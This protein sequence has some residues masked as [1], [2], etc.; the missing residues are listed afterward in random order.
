ME[1][2][3]KQKQ[4]LNE[5]LLEK[6]EPIAIVGIGM[7]LPGGNK[8][9]NDFA[10]FLNKGGDGIVDIPSDRWDNDRFY[11]D[12]AAPGSIKTRK[13]GYLDNISE[14]DPKFFNISP[15]E[16][17]YID[18]QHR[19]VLEASWQALEDAYCNVEELRD[20]NGGVFV[21]ISS[22]DYSVEVSA[23]PLEECVAPVGTGT[24]HSAVS[25]RVSYFLGWRGPCV[26]ID[27]A[28]S[29]SLV[30]LH[31]SVQAL[32]RKECNIALC[33]GVN[34]IHHPRNLIVFSNANMLSPDGRCNTFDDAANGYGRSEGCCMVVLKRLSDAIKN[35]DRIIASIR[36]SAV[37]QDG[38]SGGL[39]VPNGLAQEACMRNA[40]ND[41]ALLP[42]DINY[43]EAHG[44]GTSLGDPIELTAINQVFKDSHSKDNPIMVG[45][46]KGN[47]GHTEAAAGIIGVAKAALQLDQKKLYIQT[48]MKTRSTHVDWDNYVVDVPTQTRDWNDEKRRCIVNSFGFAGTLSSVVLEEAP[49]DKQTIT[50]AEDAP[51]SVLTLSAKSSAA[52]LAKVQEL[53]TWLQDQSQVELADVAYSSNLR[54]QF[55]QRISYPLDSDKEE[56]LTWLDRQ[57]KKLQDNKATHV[58]KPQIAFLFTGQGSQYVG[59]GSEEYQTSAIYRHAVD[60][61]DRLFHKQLGKSIKQIMLGEEENSDVLIHETMYTQAA[62]FTYEYA[63]SRYYNSIGLVPDCLL[64]HS[65]GELVALCVA[66]VVDL[67]NAIKMVSARATLMQSVTKRGSMLA[68]TSS[69]ATVRPYVDQVSNIDFAAINSPNQCV[70]SGDTEAVDEIEQLLTN[71][72]IPCKRLTTS[73]A[74]HSVH[75]SEMYEPFKKALADIQFESSKIALISNLHGS[76][77][78]DSELSDP[79]YWVRH[80]GQPVRF[81]DGVKT[82]AA[83]GNFVC[84]EVG[85]V[86]SLCA[87]GRQCAADLKW[88]PSTRK[89]RSFSSN[90]ANVVSQCF[91]MGINFDWNAYYGENNLQKLDLPFYAFDRQHYWLD[92]DAKRRFGE[93]AGDNEQ[94]PFLKNEVVQQFDGNQC[95]IFRSDISASVPVY[96]QS[97]KVFD[98]VVFPGAG[99]VET[100]IAAQLRLFGESG[101][102]IFDVNILEPLYLDDQ[103]VELQTNCTLLDSGDYNVVISS[104]TPS[105]NDDQ[106]IKRDHVSAVIGRPQGRPDCADDLADLLSLQL[107][108]WSIASADDMY[109][110]F[111][112]SGLM[113]GDEFQRLISV[114]S[115]DNDIAVADLSAGYNLNETVTPTL[116]DCAMQSVAA[117]ID[118]DS[119]YLPISFGAVTYLKQ[120]RGKLKCVLKRKAGK[121]D[122]L[123]A[124]F[125]ILDGD[126]P[127]IVVRDLTL[128]KVVTA[129]EA[130]PRKITYSTV[131]RKRTL[132]VE[133]TIVDDSHV[134]IN[135]DE[136]LQQK[137]QKLGTNY[138]LGSSFV[139]NIDDARNVLSQSEQLANRKHIVFAWAQNATLESVYS[140]LLALVNLLENDFPDIDVR[141][142]FITFGAQVI[143]KSDYAASDA[144]ISRAASLW[145]FA[146]SLLNEYPRWNASLID[147]PLQDTN[148]NYARYILEESAANLSS[149]NFIAYR[150]GQRHVK[151][152][153][154]QGMGSEH[155]DNFEV[156][157]TEY[158]L[159]QNV[160]PVKVALEP[161]AAGEVQ[162]EIRSAG[163]NFKDVLNALGL[164]KQ[165]AEEHE[166]EHQTL[167]L[168]FEAS[169]VVVAVGDGCSFKLGDS[170]MLSQLGCFKKRVNLPESLLVKKP[171]CLTHGEAAAIPTAY[172]TAYYSLVTLGRIA[173]GDR[174]LIHSAAG[175]VGQ[176]AVQIAKAVGAE[177]FATSSVSKWDH[178]RAQGVQHLMNS[179]TLDFKKEILSITREQGVDIVLNSLNKDYIPA[180]LD[181]LS[182]KGRFIELGK[183]GVWSKERVK[184]YAPEVEYHNFDLSELPIEDLNT[185][186]YEILKTVTDQIAAGEYS[187][188]PITEYDLGDMSEAF[189]VLSRGANTGKLVV[190]LT[191]ELDNKEP[192]E[193]SANFSYLITGG[194]GAL[195]QAL[196]MK[197]VE[198]GA[199][200]IAL[201][202]R[203]IPDKGVVQSIEDSLPEDVIVYPFSCDIG[204]EHSTAELFDNI[205]AM[206]IPLGG[207]FHTA[208]VLA[209]APVSSQTIESINTVFSAKVIGTD[210]LLFELGRINSSAFF[211]GYSSIASI[212]GSAGQSNY[213]AA[214]AYLD[215]RLQLEDALGKRRCIAINWGA[216][217]EIGMAATMSEQQIQSIEDRGI[218][219]L[220][221]K[222]G[223]R[224]LFRSFGS[225]VSN[226]AISEFDWQRYLN[227]MPVERDYYSLLS[228]DGASTQVSLIDLESLNDQ[229]LSERRSAISLFVR[230]SIA[231]VLHYE[232]VEDISPD[233]RFADLGLDS[234]VAVELKNGMEAALGIRLMTS[235]VFDY[236]T[237]PQLAEFLMDSIWKPEV[238][239]TEESLE[240]DVASLSDEE[241]DKALLELTI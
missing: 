1:H 149:E 87:L 196:L 64:G 66:G 105:G 234:L 51:T 197:L 163:L 126:R 214:N 131:W 169:G 139:S 18:P 240:S 167:P 41:S 82:L 235:L 142:S 81:A 144:P 3:D 228:S 63:M 50:V 193:I 5:L 2:T 208:G 204:N 179:R 206:D 156:Q 49:S 85:P 183:I 230:S 182:S 136:S 24:A 132:I 185:L 202:G 29:S 101:G 30:A 74:F 20:S 7:R 226:L 212:L 14:F 232:D 114:C 46:V 42:E 36:G 97:H 73:H 28:C 151:R 231:R 34:A 120:P 150:Q 153:A 55:S 135:F 40:I 92:I 180:G 189:E 224:R 15:K 26:S 83:R 69:E 118:A 22:I 124:D 119:T 152:V 71:N 78:S 75:M 165:Y 98:R 67:P 160:K 100:L 147:L 58:S 95:H 162:I 125:I 138:Q 172:I 209:D 201:C 168:G 35:G 80:V 137:I 221:P 210:N 130:N 61:C 86:G 19:L 146:H 205:N 65:I 186:N 157:I 192:I 103:T 227:S 174:I 239:V 175:G 133:D 70:V 116:L 191:S 13:G 94:H 128:K 187:P 148:E 215:Y 220:S 31:Q 166:I 218:Y 178:L 115:N 57:E 177:I 155:A 37:N 32:R 54:P 12:S 48:S 6:Y 33:G 53:K 222:E 190:N 96:L 60:A 62:L 213:A 47:I 199:K 219:M 184:E 93:T 217:A 143:D 27:T 102:A 223:L 117:L 21:G 107:D 52:L 106:A 229:N 108:S 112:Q 129:Q 188:L 84:I 123:L 176:A 122:E 8:S 44:T 241:L 134:F 91:D 171:D 11:S 195:G 173:K 121:D 76:V 111:E 68:I 159:F 237:I 127:V 25:G 236:P 113:Y 181:V 79:D 225:G 59:M 194:F 170:V 4:L 56:L 16:A 104:Y 90:I 110:D 145:G 23:M 203:R 39:T 99:F 88:L 154:E 233:A 77:A 45:S 161:P 43:V 9:R 109:P 211:V 140:D 200:H 10:E 89:N 141:L 38:E 238:A 198:R 164:L 216:W 207:I 158:G 17:K 72:D